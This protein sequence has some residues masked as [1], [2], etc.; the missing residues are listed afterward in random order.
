MT[1]SS[2]RSLLC[3]TA[4]MIALSAGCLAD[5]T[6]SAANG[7]SGNGDG[8]NGDGN[9]TDGNQSL[10]ENAVDD[11]L[12]DG[13]A[14]YDTQSFHHSEQSSSPDAALLLEAGDAN[15]W[16]SERSLQSEPLA[17]FVDETDFE[18]SVIVALEAGA[19]NPCYELVLDEIDID[20]GDESEDDDELVLD[21]AVRD[22]SGANEVCT[23]QIVTAGRLVR[24]TFDSERL[25]RVSASIVD[26]DGQEHG[27][28]IASESASASAGD[29]SSASSGNESAADD[30]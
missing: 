24:A 12:P 6:N 8:G 10:N 18:T 15:E 11:D 3:G 19:P 14:S 4:S 28:G 21:A 30:S 13:L 20:D 1:R 29:G 17:G 16:L 27:I 7:D 26:S 23:G 5:D 22:T 25:T 9:Q 2:R